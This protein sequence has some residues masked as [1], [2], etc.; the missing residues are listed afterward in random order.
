MEKAMTVK[1]ALKTHS[2]IRKYLESSKLIWFKP[3]DNFFNYF[4]GP[5]WKWRKFHDCGAGVGLLTAE[6]HQR[7][8]D[9][10][11]YDMFARDQA[12]VKVAKFDTATIAEK[13]DWSEVALL[14]R[15]CHHEDFIDKTINSALEM[16]EAFYIG[17]MSNLNR[18]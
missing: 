7:N 16:G 18:D 17:L 5:N 11:A 15:P 12:M 4:Q 2:S 10:V 13:M 6:M 1:R 14:A 8:M 9:C 3:T